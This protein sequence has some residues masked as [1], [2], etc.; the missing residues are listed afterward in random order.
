MPLLAHLACKTTEIL[1]SKPGV[2]GGTKDTGMT[3]R[4]RNTIPGLTHTLHT[5]FPEARNLPKHTNACRKFVLNK[6]NEAWAFLK[7]DSQVPDF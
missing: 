6:G 7:D 4:D 3:Q 1:K 5:V 2:E